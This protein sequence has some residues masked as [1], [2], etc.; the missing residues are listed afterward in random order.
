MNSHELARNAAIAALNK[1]AEQVRIF[2]LR[3]LSSMF[4]YFVIC[5]GITDVHVRAV[6][7]AIEDDLREIGVRP[8]HA[9]G[10]SVG[11]WVVL[12]YGDVVV[13]IFQPA[14][15]EFYGLERFWGDAKIEEITHESIET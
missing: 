8:L 12:D 9:E 15:R 11:R 5:S 13:H 1:K 14:V 10:A 4:D 2:D 7:N 3:T 6:S